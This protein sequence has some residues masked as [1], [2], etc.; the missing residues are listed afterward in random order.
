MGSD[1]R[2]PEKDNTQTPVIVTVTVSHS[3]KPQE[4][5][6]SSNTICSQ[7]SGDP[8]SVRVHNSSY[9]LGHAG[10]CFKLCTAGAHNTVCYPPC[11][12]FN[13]GLSLFL[14]VSIP[15]QLRRRGSLFTDGG[16]CGQTTEDKLHPP[17]CRAGVTKDNECSRSL[18][19]PI[20]QGEANGYGLQRWHL[21]RREGRSMYSVVQKTRHWGRICRGEREREREGDGPMGYV[22]A[23]G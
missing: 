8:Y 23:S 4:N 15:E 13:L 9:P 19:M 22:S 17:G 18:E 21:F 20:G 14:L 3:Q 10:P 12:S 7:Q 1:G 11:R 2:Y 16:G 5:S 6:S